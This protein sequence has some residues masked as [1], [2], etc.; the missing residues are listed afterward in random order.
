MGD[1]C[2]EEMGGEEKAASGLIQ[3]SLLGAIHD[4]QFSVTSVPDIHV[5]LLSASVRDAPR[6]LVFTGP[7]RDQR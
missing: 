5:G 4:P 2:K 1:A 3:F 7:F 6:N